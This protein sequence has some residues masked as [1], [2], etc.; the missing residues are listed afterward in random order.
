MAPNTFNA[1]DSPT[2]I[3]VGEALATIDGIGLITK[4]TLAVLVQAPFVRT[5]V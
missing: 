2:Q 5:K 3:W 4:V 1:T